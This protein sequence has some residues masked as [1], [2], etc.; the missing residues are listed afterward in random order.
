MENM[1]RCTPRQVRKFIIECIQAGLVPF[2]QSSPGMGKST[3]VRE[4][5]DGFDLAGIDHRLSTSD[6]TDIN[7]FPHVVNGR[8]TFIPFDLFPVRG[9]PLPKNPDGSEKEGW[10]LFLDEMNAAPKSVQAAAYKLILDKMVGQHHLHE[11]VAIVAAGNLSTDRAITNSLSTAMQSRVIHLEME[12][13]FQEWLEDVALKQGYDSRIIAFLSQYEEKLM[14]FRPDHQEKTFCCPR[15]WEFVNRLIKGK[16]LSD[17]STLLLAGTI[18]SGVAAEFVQFC[19]IFKNLVTVQEILRDPENCFIP[20][21]LNLKWA[22]MTHMLEKIDDKNFE[23]LAIYAN[24]FDMSFRVL[25]FRSLM[26][27]N[28]DLRTHPSFGKSMREITQYLSAA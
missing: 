20:A 28:R 14:D 4:I 16:E 22:T 18:T 7:G 10:L 24:R 5:G 17:E 3:I 12:V 15:T 8:A 1:Y 21:D 2:V 6:P 27:R 26:V 23:G 9:T 13:S 19:K 11:R 25:F